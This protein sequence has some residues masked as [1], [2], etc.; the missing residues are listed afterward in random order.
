MGGGLGIP[1]VVRVRG[2][3]IHQTRGYAK[4]PVC[5]KLQGL[6]TGS[7]KKDSVLCEV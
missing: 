2:T 6:V 4:H 7:K 1:R 5:F 3:T